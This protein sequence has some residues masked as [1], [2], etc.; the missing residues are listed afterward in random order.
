M[1]EFGPAGFAAA[2]AA[3]F[4]SFISPCVLPLVPGYL[5]FVTGVDTTSKDVARKRVVVAMTLFVA[6]FTA[7]F[8]ALGA[9]TAWF[10][11]A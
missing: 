5:S 9:G 3:G 4:V 2:F 10:G 8:I 6:G 7:M 1:I 11:S